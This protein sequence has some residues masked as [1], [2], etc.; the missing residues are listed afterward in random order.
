MPPIATRRGQYEPKVQQA[1][2]S[3][4]TIPLNPADKTKDPLARADSLHHHVESDSQEDDKAAEEPPLSR[5][6]WQNRTFRRK[7]RRQAPYKHK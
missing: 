6:R 2:L 1:K 5:K 7:G 3:P 4:D